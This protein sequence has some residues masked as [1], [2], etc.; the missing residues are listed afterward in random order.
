MGTTA[1]VVVPG[2]RD[3]EAVA[4]DRL[5]DLERR[6]SRFLPTS[7]VSRLN[8]ASGARTFVSSETY[9]VVRAAVSAWEATAGMFDPTVH[10]SVVALGYDRTFS[11]VAR[12]A[13]TVEPV[14]A[15]GCTGIEFGGPGDGRWIFL[16]ENVALDLGGIGKGRAADLVV[17]ELLA[18]GASGACVNVGGDLRVGGDPPTDDGWIVGVD[19]PFLPGREVFQ[20]ALASGAVTTTSRMRRQW[21][22]GGA[23]LHHVL[24]P[25]SGAP[26]DTPV[27]AVTVIAATAAE[28]EV[29]ATAVFVDEARS[30]ALLEGAGAS[31]LVIEETRRVRCLGDVE[32]YAA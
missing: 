19:D 27:A 11:D 8:R 21:D 26:V 30:L 2:R 6:W 10:D 4:I 18:A 14:A 1:H 13:Q 7:E 25:R 12:I 16:P 22:R 15:P 24:D 31:A 17:G 29:L 32:S 20:I 9:A 5:R 28:A 3:L 23:R